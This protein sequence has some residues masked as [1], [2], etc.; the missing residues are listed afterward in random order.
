MEWYIWFSVQQIEQY[1]TKFQISN[2]SS[3]N[4]LVSIHIFGYMSVNIHITRHIG[5][6]DKV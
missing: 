4:Y 5:Q 3:T 2:Q 6:R 1:H